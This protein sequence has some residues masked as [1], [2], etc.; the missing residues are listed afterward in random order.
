V[1][2][3]AIFITIANFLAMVCVLTNHFII[4]WKAGSGNSSVISVLL[5][6]IV[7]IRNFLKYNIGLNRELFGAIRFRHEVG[8][9]AT[10][11]MECCIGHLAPVEV[12]PCSNEVRGSEAYKRKT[13]WGWM[14]C[15]G[16]ALRKTRHCCI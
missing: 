7:P 1:E 12:L 2:T 5:L 15:T 8:A 11:K 10:S 14:F 4:F 3:Q 16:I 6:P 9:H 13:G